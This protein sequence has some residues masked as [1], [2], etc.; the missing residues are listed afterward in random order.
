[1]V[2]ILAVLRA[3]HPTLPTAVVHNNYPAAKRLVSLLL[4]YRYGLHGAERHHPS[5]LPVGSLCYLPPSK[6]RRSCYR[7][8]WRRG[9]TD[10]I[11]FLGPGFAVFFGISSG[12]LR[13]EPLCWPPHPTVAPWIVGLVIGLALT[14]RSQCARQG[15]K[16]GASTNP[17]RIYRFPPR[18][19][20]A[21]FQEK[22][23]KS[24]RF[25]KPGGV[26]RVTL[27][28]KKISHRSMWLAPNR[29]FSKEQ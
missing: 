20:F 24:G 11:L 9:A 29:G 18:T 21:D 19:S 17:I 16:T 12:F 6:R 5:C 4:I 13:L 14:F 8:R 3:W 15:R 28:E 7:V 23:G 2:L 26:P 10:A 25:F 1:M 22:S 27:A